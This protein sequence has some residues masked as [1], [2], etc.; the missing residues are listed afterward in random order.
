MNTLMLIKHIETRTIA[1][2]YFNSENEAVWTWSRLPMSD[3]W[4]VIYLEERKP[5][6]H[7]YELIYTKED[8]KGILYPKYIICLS[9]KEALYLKNKIERI[10]QNYIIQIKKLY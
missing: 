5:S 6:G 4:E 8:E 7:R 1:A 10:N 9:K 2:Q 3:E